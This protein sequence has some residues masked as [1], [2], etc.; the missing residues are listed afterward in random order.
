MET[1]HKN[2]K[3]LIKRLSDSVCFGKVVIHDCCKNS[4]AYKIDYYQQMLD[5][6]RE[7]AK[8]EGITT[9][10]NDQTQ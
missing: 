1:V 7:E 9:I 2:D 8:Q 10:K 6:F 3:H 5:E 4:F